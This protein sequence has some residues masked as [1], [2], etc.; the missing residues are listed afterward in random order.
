MSFCQQLKD[1]CVSSTD[2]SAAQRL[3]E[4]TG[5]QFTH[6]GTPCCLPRLKGESKT[7]STLMC[8]SIETTTGKA[9]RMLMASQWGCE[10]QLHA[11]FCHGKAESI[12]YY[13]IF[14]QNEKA[15]MK[16]PWRKG[17]AGQEGGLKWL[18]TVSQINHPYTHVHTH[19]AKILTQTHVSCDISL[20]RW[21]VELETCQTVL[22]LCDLSA[23]FWASLY[24][25]FKQSKLLVL[26]M[27]CWKNIWRH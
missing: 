24:V 2:S 25:L 19:T 3:I 13:S 5:L 22:T 1:H 20:S 16:S 4:W 6:W 26:F 21:A 15:A 17:R 10:A 14:A 18:W 23:R 12:L 11:A 27:G 8:V 7:P 9:G